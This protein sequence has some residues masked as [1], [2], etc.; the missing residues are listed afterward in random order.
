MDLHKHRPKCR[1]SRNPAQSNKAYQN[2]IKLKEK[3]RNVEETGW[4]TRKR[5]QQVQNARKHEQCMKGK[6]K[7]SNPSETCK[8]DE[9]R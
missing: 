2:L 4:T 8:S 5:N 9:E 3:R 1:F 7:R 6:H